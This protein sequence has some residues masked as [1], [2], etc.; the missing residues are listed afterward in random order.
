MQRLKSLMLAAVAVGA[1]TGAPSQ[2]RP[3]L[4]LKAAV[5]KE[6]VEGD[7]QGAIALYKQIVSNAAA[8]RQVAAAALLGL[9]GCYEKLGEA[10]AAE[11]RRAYE[12]L[13]ADYSDQSQQ[14]AQARARLTALNAGSGGTSSLPALRMAF[15]LS[16][17][18]ATTSAS[19]SPDGRRVA[20]VSWDTG[21]LAVR[22]LQSGQS[23]MVTT[24]ERN[25]GYDDSFAASPVW[26]PDGK[27]LAYWWYRDDGYL[28]ELR[29]ADLSGKNIRVLNSQPESKGPELTPVGWFA[30]G[31]ALLAT[32]RWSG[33]ATTDI[34]RVSLEG[35]PINTVRQI[36]FSRSSR[37]CLSPDGKY[38]AFDESTDPDS[39]NMDVFVMDSSGGQAV[40]VATGPYDD[41]LLDWTP[42]GRR[43]LVASNRSG[44]YDAWLV[45]V[46]DGNTVGL[47]Q[48]L[49]KELGLVAPIGFS[50][51]GSFY[52]APDLATRDVMVADWSPE[53]RRAASAPRPATEHFSGSTR[54]PAWSPDGRKLAYL[55]DRGRSRPAE[56]RVR[57]RDVETGA[58]RTLAD[59][60]GTVYFL[61]WSPDGTSV[62]ITV[63]RPRS[64]SKIEILDVTSGKLTREFASPRSGESIGAYVWGPAG[65]VVYYV[66]RGTGSQTVLWRRDLRTGDEITLHT[67]EGAN[68]IAFAVSPDGKQLAIGYN[69]QIMVIAEGGGEPRKLVSD[70][71]G[72]EAAGTVAWTPDGRH[73]YFGQQ[74]A[75]TVRLHSVPVTGGPVEDLNFEIGE[76]S[77]FRPDGRQ[78]AFTRNQGENRREIWVMENFLPAAKARK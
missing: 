15:R 51:D 28:Y 1:L 35:G 57:I 41:R 59:V 21:D 50:R 22:D 47:P 19:I 60:N 72:L 46:R 63:A 64:P 76:R 55:V 20:Y 77:R 31:T 70:A 53:S 66:A 23:H 17:S 27:R 25:W 3:D 26:A 48:L 40:P 67:R 5:Y 61:A 24:K 74:V 16:D 49:R 65:D 56:T 42:D 14:A 71:A 2:D 39:L 38:I 43:I 30:D 34:V 29:I 32:A 44:T 6:T 7:L 4:Q 68:P 18:T 13:V 58:E 69:R 9:G 62:A 75:G 10:Q 78:L 8:P 36:R 52:Y 11:A 54:L 45:Q 73:I 12:R 33:R 37:V